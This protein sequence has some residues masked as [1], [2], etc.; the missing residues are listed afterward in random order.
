MLWRF[1]P[2]AATSTANTLTYIHIASCIYTI[3][4]FAVLL[5]PGN[6]FQIC[7]LPDAFFSMFS[8][9]L[10][11]FGAVLPQRWRAQGG[12]RKRTP[13]IQAPKDAVPASPFLVLRVDQTLKILHP[14]LPKI[15]NNILHQTLDL[16]RVQFSSD[17]PRQLLI[18]DSIRVY[19][20]A[21]ITLMTLLACTSSLMKPSH[22][23]WKRCISKK[24]KKAL[25]LAFC[26]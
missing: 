2:L 18:Q 4:I 25:D 7:L 9:P 16:N 6:H 26:L 11:R 3:C 21:K 5:P 1:Y 8:L 12:I 22:G 17:A 15:L 24:K 10:Q 13:E 20:Q 14:I 23:S 19:I